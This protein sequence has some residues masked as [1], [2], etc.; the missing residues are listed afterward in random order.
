[1]FPKKLQYKLDTRKENNALRQ[2]G[3][4]KNLIDF[5]SN[6][7]LGF[8]KSEDLFNKTHQFLIDHNIK[9]NGATGSRLL[10]GNHTLYNI[11]ENQLCKFHTTTW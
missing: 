8:S 6:D 5:S 3:L 9:K 4:N 11:V 2:L 1:M 7:Y 10:S